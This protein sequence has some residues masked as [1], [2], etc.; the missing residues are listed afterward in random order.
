MQ[1]KSIVLIDAENVLNG[2][3][4]YCKENNLNGK[5][6]YKKLVDKLSEGTNL[7]RAYFY[8]GVQENTPVRKKNFLT[9]LQRNEIQLRTKV[10]KN[11]SYTCC[12]CNKQNN[13]QVQKGVDVSLATDILRH[14][15]Q[16][17]SDVCIVV[18]GDEDYKD[19]IEAAKDKGMKVWVASFLHCLSNEL[20]NNVDKVIFIEDI[21]DRITLVPQKGE[22]EKQKV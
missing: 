19:A 22:Q 21:F 7:L 17:T 4:R 9:A 12:H 11:R 15:W 6:D 16:E 20:R 18:S 5:L 2:W 1:E 3:F 10:L 13:R 8:D 14:A